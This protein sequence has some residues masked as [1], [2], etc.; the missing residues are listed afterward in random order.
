MWKRYRYFTLC[1]LIFLLATAGVFGLM[2]SGLIRADYTVNKLNTAL[3]AGLDEQTSVIVPYGRYA[4]ISSLG[5]IDGRAYLAIKGKADGKDD[6]IFSSAAAEDGEA[7]A[8]DGIYV[9][10]RQEADTQESLVLPVTFD[11]VCGQAGK[12]VLLQTQTGY[13]LVDLSNLEAR[14]LSAWGIDMDDEVSLSA[15]GKYLTMFRRDPDVVAEENE[16]EESDSSDCLCRLFDLQGNV[17]YEAEQRFTLTGAANI[18]V[19][20]EKPEMAERRTRTD[21]SGASYQVELMMEEQPQRFIDVRTGKT[22][23]TLQKD[24]FYVDTAGPYFVIGSLIEPEAYEGK[25]QDQEVDGPLWNNLYFY[26]LDMQGKLAMDGQLF[27]QA[28]WQAGKLVAEVFAGKRIDAPDAVAQWPL[29]PT[30]LRVYDAE[31]KLLYTAPEGDILAM[32][33][34]DMLGLMR[35]DRLFDYV[36][37]DEQGKAEILWQGQDMLCGTDAEDGTVLA[38][39]L[40]EGASRWDWNSAL[41]ES[42]MNDILFGADDFRDLYA[43]V[44]PEGL[45]RCGEA[46]FSNAQPSVC[47]YAVVQ[48]KDEYAVLDLQERG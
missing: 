1:G 18:A 25:R 14:D 8:E 13:T 42:W 21:E 11:Y 12:S 17:L 47:G 43:E 44:T 20:G 46:V 22:L 35:P 23:F 4:Y 16:T 7:C 48:E 27:K 9:L 31:E 6:G 45:K 29:E 2:Q 10:E 5:E 40:P 38:H 33:S 34:G 39:V 36:Q 3:Q 15:D 24:D 37:I 32:C 26:L 28:H 19:V 41:L 30:E